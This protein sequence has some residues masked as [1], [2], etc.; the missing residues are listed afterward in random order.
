VACLEQ[1]PE[2]SEKLRQLEV[3][4]LLECKELADALLSRGGQPP[5]Q[6]NPQHG[7]GLSFWQRGDDYPL[8]LWRTNGPAVRSHSRT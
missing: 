7:I 5:H 2:V 6:L 1:A 4:H 8:L 3:A